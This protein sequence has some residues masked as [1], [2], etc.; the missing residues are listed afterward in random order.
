M[1]NKIP[2]MHHKTEKMIREIMHNVKLTNATSLN[3]YKNNR[4][5]RVDLRFR[6][7]RFRVWDYI[8]G[9]IIGYLPA[10]KHGSAWRVVKALT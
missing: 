8:D 2:K 3:I 5:I 9:N 4:C 7:K 6:E 10:E 1:T